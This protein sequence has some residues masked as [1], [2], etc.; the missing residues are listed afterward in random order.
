MATYLPCP[1]CGGQMNAAGRGALQGTAHYFCLTCAPSL[2]SK[3]LHFGQIIRMGT[4]DF[5]FLVLDARPQLGNLY[6]NLSAARGGP[7]RIGDRVLVLLETSLQGNSVRALYPTSP[8]TTTGILVPAG[9]PPIPPRQSRRWGTVGELKAP[10]WGFITD[11]ETGQSI[12]VH[13]SQCR[14]PILR[15]GTRVCYTPTVGARGRSASDVVA[16]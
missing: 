4:K 8:R 3:Q 7:L 2:R 15:V 10:D 11:H 1:H 14:G 13:A 5:G 12:F 16:A 9:R 6:F